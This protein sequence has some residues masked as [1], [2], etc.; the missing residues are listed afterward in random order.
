LSLPAGR[1]LPE[2][3]RNE[4]RAARDAKNLTEAEANLVERLP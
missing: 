1:P 3:I 2:L 4:Y